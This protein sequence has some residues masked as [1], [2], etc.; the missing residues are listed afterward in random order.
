MAEIQITPDLVE[1]ALFLWM[2]AA[3]ERGDLALVEDWE[4]ERE[5]AYLEPSG[6]ARE[7]A[8]GALASSRF[9]EL[10]LGAPL[11]SSLEHCPHASTIIERVLVRKVARP[12]DEGSELYVDESNDGEATSARL[13]LAICAQ[14]FLDPSALADLT[15]REYLHAE[16]ML[17]PEFG[18]RPALS[19]D[20]P[21]EPARH[22]LVRDRS[23]MLWEARVAGRMAA[24]QD[25]QDP[26]PDP[27][28]IFQR[29]FSS[30]SG[31]RCLALWSAAWYQRLGTW[32]GMIEVAHT[33]GD[34]QAQLDQGT[35]CS[36]TP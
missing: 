13:T 19:P 34:A 9:R 30:L 16:D 25:A 15:L 28:P 27:P 31:E 23:R 10:E 33:C 6:A 29:A 1:E 11:S 24:L 22:E 32:D 17:D 14:T 2:R 35:P 12:R 36:P 26:L 21:L 4:R 7:A 3:S 20:Q 5:S 18:Y 8:F